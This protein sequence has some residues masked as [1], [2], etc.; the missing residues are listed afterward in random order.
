VVFDRQTGQPRAINDLLRRRRDLHPMVCP[1]E[2]LPP[3]PTPPSPPMTGDAGVPFP[4][5]PGVMK[6]GSP[7]SEPATTV[8][9][10]IDRVH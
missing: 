2:P 7:I 10:G 6:G 9:K 8:G 4:V 1:D 5:G 3:L